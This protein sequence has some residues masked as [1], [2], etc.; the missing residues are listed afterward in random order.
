VGHVPTGFFQLTGDATVA[1]MESDPQRLP[2][3]PTRLVG[4]GSGTLQGV[5][6]SLRGQVT[7]A[8]KLVDGASPPPVA[9]D[10]TAR[11]H[12]GQ[13]RLID[14]LAN[15][16]G[17]VRRPRQVTQPACGSVLESGKDVFFQAPRSGCP[18]GVT[19]FTYVATD[20]VRR[21]APATVTVIVTHP[22]HS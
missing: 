11:I 1:D 8:W 12:A 15:D 22:K 3:D 19:I 13:T 9:V 6:G 17:T 10:D 2:R 4:S 21:S 18:G 5:A 7:M 20:G 14:L 16:T